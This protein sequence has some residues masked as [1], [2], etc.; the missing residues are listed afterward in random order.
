MEVHGKIRSYQNYYYVAAK[1]EILN[2]VSTNFM[3][4]IDFFDNVF[5][6]YEVIRIQWSFVFRQLVENAEV[7]YNFLFGVIENV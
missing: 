2:F 3:E 1:Y 5:I 4:E 7:W 6:I